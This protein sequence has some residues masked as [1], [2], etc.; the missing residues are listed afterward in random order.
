MALKL[1]IHDEFDTAD[2]LTDAMGHIVGLIEQ[3]YTS[4]HYPGWTLEGEE[5]SPL[6]PPSADWNGSEPLA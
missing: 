6:D 3:G 2:A 4:G 1:T 5:F